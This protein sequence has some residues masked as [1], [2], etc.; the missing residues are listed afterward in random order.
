[1]LD[2]SSSSPGLIFLIVIPGPLQVSRRIE[3]YFPR[4]WLGEVDCKSV[5]RREEKNTG[6]VIVSL[7]LLTMQQ[8]INFHF[9]CCEG[10]GAYLGPRSA[11]NIQHTLTIQRAIPVQDDLY[12]FPLVRDQMVGCK[13]A[14]LLC[15]LSRPWFALLIF[16]SIFF[17]SI[18]CCIEQACLPASQ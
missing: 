5:C 1:M 10:L 17:I 3:R 15:V 6:R 13:I 7:A 2:L 8:I 18:T 9:C 11:L 12:N 16:D 14:R 4:W